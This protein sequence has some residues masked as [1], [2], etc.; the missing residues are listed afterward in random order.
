[1]QLR[2]TVLTQASP[3][4]VFAYLSDF[5]TTTE[6]DPG[7]VSTVRI[8]GDGGVGTTY[9]NVSKFLGRESELTYT[10]EELTTPRKIALRGENKTVTAH[11]TMELKAAGAGTEVTYTADFTFKGVARFVAPLLAPALKKLGDDAEEGLA[12]ALGKLA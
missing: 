3:D 6:W 12:D 4:R 8:Q 10:V 7:T 5:T 11:D 9:R 2:R 1:M